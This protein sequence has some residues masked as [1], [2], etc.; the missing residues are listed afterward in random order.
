LVRWR[1]SCRK[2]TR[3][4]SRRNQ[5]GG[6]VEVARGRGLSFSRCGV[7]ITGLGL[8]A[9][10]PK[11][12]RCGPLPPDS[13]PRPTE[14]RHDFIYR[15]HHANVSRCTPVHHRSPRGVVGQH[16]Y[17]M[18]P[19]NVMLTGGMPPA[20]AFQPCAPVNPRLCF[21]QGYPLCIPFHSTNRIPQDA[22]LTSP[23]VP[24]SVSQPP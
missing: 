7:R 5:S 20:Q 2:A 14:H 19:L 3:A 23:E 6:G 12:S 18:H 17:S 22:H 15:A 21:C 10:R 9:C 1:T 13:C 16:H 8:P 24:H 4:R 11:A